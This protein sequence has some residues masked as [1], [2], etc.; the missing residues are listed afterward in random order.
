MSGRVSFGVAVDVAKRPVVFQAQFGLYSG[1]APRRSRNA[2]SRRRPEWSARRAACVGFREGRS[3]GA[4]TVEHDPEQF[5][6][7]RV[8]FGG[9]GQVGLGVGDAV[10]LL[11]GDSGLEAVSGAGDPLQRLVRR[12]DAA[13]RIGPLDLAL[14][15]AALDREQA[16]PVIVQERRQ[17][18]PGERVDLEGEAL[19][20]VVVAEVLAHHVGVLAFDQGIVVAAPGARPGE[21][22]M[23]LGEQV[24]HPVVD[25]LRAV[26]GVEPPDAEGH[27]FEQADQDGQQ[28]ALRDGRDRGHQFEL[29]R[30]IDQVDQ[31]DALDAVPVA[32][33]HRVDAQESGLPVGLGR[34]ARADRD[35]RGAG[36]VARRPA[37]PVAP[38]LAQV[39]DVAG[40]DARQTREPR[41]AEQP[42]LP[43]QHFRRRRPRH[44][45]VGLVDLGQQTDVGGPV[46]TRKIAAAIAGPQVHNAARVA[47]SADQAFYLRQRQA[48][49]LR[50]IT[51]DR[52][53]VRAT[54]AL[55]SEGHER[56]A[57]K[58]VRCLAVQW[59]IVNRFVAV[60]ASPN[61]FQCRHAT[62][63]E[64][65]NHSP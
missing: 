42:V 53:L 9:G 25:V 55:V 28:E 34:L 64:S 51:A 26:V 1:V 45:P 46:D 27:L 18:L 3:C 57:H 58:L 47:V 49:E 50:Q 39:V 13:A 36:L 54:Q 5:A 62:G 29:G 30:L 63:A 43:A 32:L 44:L 20:D 11:E 33:M 38:G 15:V 12:G 7:G 21:L 61:L 40:R 22:D 52:S 35:R 37:Q 23:E 17:A 65:H 19:G 16:G 48:G 8:E 41:V 60:Q 6:L 56:V 4:G 31:V 10:E 24:G 2:G 14:G 59:V